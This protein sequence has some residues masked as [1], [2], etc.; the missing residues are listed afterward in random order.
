MAGWF[1]SMGVIV[2]KGA[3]PDAGYLVLPRSASIAALWSFICLTAVAGFGAAMV[4]GRLD[5]LEANDKRTEVYLADRRQVTE[6]RLDRLE[7]T[8]SR[9]ARLEG[10]T[11][12][13][14][15]LLRELK[16]RRP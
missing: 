12:S 5:A 1:P 14:L 10:K 13:I 11:D 7:A 9:I 8:E 16:D 2:G 15:D 4:Y 3:L 6:K